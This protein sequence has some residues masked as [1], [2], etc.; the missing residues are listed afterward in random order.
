MALAPLA[1]SAASDAADALLDAP[2]AHASAR[3]SPLLA[4]A[5]ELIFVAAVYFF[6]R[7]LKMGA[8]LAQGGT[9]WP[10]QTYSSLA[11]DGSPNHIFAW[12]LRR[13]PPL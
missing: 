2:V 10:R 6:W 3:G 11:T 13:S 7:P 8:P 9:G 12:T 5:A 1:L 4:I